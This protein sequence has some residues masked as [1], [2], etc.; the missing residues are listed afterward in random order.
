LEN[1]YFI[2]SL[3]K[4]L[5]D[6]ALLRNS[7]MTT[8][9]SKNSRLFISFSSLFDDCLNKSE[10]ELSEQFVYSISALDDGRDA[11]RLVFDKARMLPNEV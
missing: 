8:K 1:L 5:I 6:E 7:Q 11:N 2:I 10:S 4:G 9:K 3:F